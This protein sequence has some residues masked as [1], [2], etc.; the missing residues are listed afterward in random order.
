MPEYITTDIEISS[1]NSDREN[2]GEENY[3]ELN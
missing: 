2:S 3:N 1:D